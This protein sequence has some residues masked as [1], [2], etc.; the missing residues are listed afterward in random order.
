[1]MLQ[2][3]IKRLEQKK[4]VTATPSVD[5]RGIENLKAQKEVRHQKLELLER[6]NA[7]LK[8]EIENLSRKN[9]AA[10]SRIRVLEKEVNKGK[11]SV[12]TLLEKA[13]NDDELIEALRQER[14]DIRHDMQVLKRS[15][16]DNAAQFG[17]STGQRSNLEATIRSQVQQLEHQQ[18]LI[19]SLKRDASTKKAASQEPSTEIKRLK[20]ELDQM[21]TRF[22]NLVLEKEDRIADLEEKLEETEQIRHG[23]ESNDIQVRD[24]TEE[25]EFLTVELQ[26]LKKRYSKLLERLRD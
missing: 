26:K 24:L 2:A 23:D 25:N 21:R 3:R 14:Q 19:A 10:K 4:D 22:Q 1:M 18:E 9:D 5:T 7:K 15:Q 11:S 13:N 12:K 16:G 8:Q 20:S 17:S 6:S